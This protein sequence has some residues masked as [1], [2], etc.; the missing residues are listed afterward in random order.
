MPFAS[1][2]FA[3]LFLTIG[4]TAKA[5]LLSLPCSRT[6]ARSIIPSPPIRNAPRSSSIKA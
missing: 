2:L 4:G 6:L 1:F 5:T 3:V